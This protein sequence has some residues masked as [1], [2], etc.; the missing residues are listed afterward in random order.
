[1][2][3]AKLFKRQEAMNHLKKEQFSLFGK[4]YWQKFLLKNCYVSPNYE[5]YINNPNAD[6]NGEIA[7]KYEC[8]WYVVQQLS[9]PEIDGKN[10]IDEI[11]G[12]STFCYD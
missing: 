11:L 10:T 8:V 1:M 9:A 3:M 7:D 12:R 6:M 2:K 5:Y 4:L